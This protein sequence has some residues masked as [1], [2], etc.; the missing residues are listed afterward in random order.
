[1]R[2]V[3]AYIRAVE[4]LNHH[5]GRMAI[6]LLFVMAGVLLYSS[7]SKAFLLPSLWTLEMAQFLMAAY[8]LLGGP[9]SMQQGAHV[10]MDLAYGFWPPR[11]KAA[12]DAFT[13]LFLLFFLGVL[14]FGG[15]VSAQYAVEYQE[16]SYSVWR[17]Y[18]APIKIIMCIAIA[19]ML[20]QASAEFLK[21]L[22]RALGRTPPPTPQSL[23]DERAA[24]KAAAREAAREE[25]RAAREAQ[26][27]ARRPQT[28]ADARAAQREEKQAALYTAR[29]PHAEARP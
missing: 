23:R 19:L 13:S 4:V 25:T 11:V 26:I 3:R 22:L 2:W 5:V 17:P 27:E 24:E 14:L 10:R 8:Y 16:R 12:V 15:I 21:D 28:R 7:I 1:M 29:T 9:Y 18:M 6:W 20:L